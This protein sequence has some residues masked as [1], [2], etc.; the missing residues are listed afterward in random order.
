MKPELKITHCEY[1][2]SII[3]L[4]SPPSKNRYNNAEIHISNGMILIPDKIVKKRHKKGVGDS[5]ANFLSG[6]YCQPECLT[7]K[8]KE[9]L[10]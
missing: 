3:M 9:L 1:C 8:I 5:H 4:E 2:N 7:N 6:Y 10:T